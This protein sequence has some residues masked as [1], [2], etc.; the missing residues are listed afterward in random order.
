MCDAEGWP[1][2]GVGVL[3]ESRDMALDILFKSREKRIHEGA[4]VSVCLPGL[5]ALLVLHAVIDFDG[6]GR[7]AADPE[8]A[9]Y[10]QSAS[11]AVPVGEGVHVLEG[12]VEPGDAR[13]RSRECKE[14]VF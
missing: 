3:G 5:E 6:D 14:L 4:G 7:K 2:S 11:A 10:P 1:L 12:S 8:L 13:C 9:V